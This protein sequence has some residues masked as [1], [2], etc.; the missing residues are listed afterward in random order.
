[1]LNSWVTCELGLNLTHKYVSIPQY[2]SLLYPTTNN[3][4]V[5]IF[6]TK[7]AA[8]VICFPA[9]TKH[10]S[11]EHGGVISSLVKYASGEPQSSSG[12]FVLSCAS[13]W[14]VTATAENTRNSA[15]VAIDLK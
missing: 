7:S 8:S 6:G 14:A 12:T 2:R 5:L 9:S 1:M 13:C 10:E 3:C 4:F 11:L 15:S